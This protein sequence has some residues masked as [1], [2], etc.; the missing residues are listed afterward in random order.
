MQRQVPKRPESPHKYRGFS[1]CAIVQWKR[2]IYVAQG[3]VKEHVKG[4]SKI[5]PS[6]Q[7]G[8][9]YLGWHG[10]DWPI[11]GMGHLDSFSNLQGHF[12]FYVPFR[13]GGGADKVCGRFPFFRHWTLYTFPKLF[14]SRCEYRMHQ[15]TGDTHGSLVTCHHPRDHSHLMRNIARKMGDWLTNKWLRGCTH[16]I[17]QQKLQFLPP[18][19]L[20]NRFDQI[21][22]WPI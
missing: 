3:F 13:E 22:D 19:P 11:K 15:Q 14:H 20:C 16:I 4:W 12:R 5:H 2:P 9:H 7:T 17:Q 21:S 6:W 18:S 1:F 8:K 10:N